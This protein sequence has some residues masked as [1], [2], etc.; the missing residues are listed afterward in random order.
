MWCLKWLSASNSIVLF[1]TDCLNKKA[2]L[3]R[4]DCLASR[5]HTHTRVC[6]YVRTQD[7]HADRLDM[8]VEW[9]SGRVV[10]HVE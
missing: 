8:V 7:A 10:D 6:A 5:A 3:F 2:L 9:L 4:A 1:R